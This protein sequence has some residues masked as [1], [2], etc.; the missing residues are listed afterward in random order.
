IGFVDS[1]EKGASMCIATP[2]GPDA[3]NR[4]EDVKAIQILLNMN[5]DRAG[6]S[7]ALLED[8]AWGTHT[9]EAVTTFQRVV[10]G[11]S[12]P[13]GHIAP[14]DGTLAALQAGMPDTFS[15]FKLQG[16]MPRAREEDVARF[17][18]QLVPTALAYKID[19]ALRQAH[20]FAQIGHE[21]GALRF[22][23]ELASGDA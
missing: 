4:F 23:E 12:N 20:F 7:T 8:G 6:I 2:V 10:M 3:S 18:P 19:T 22:T 13:G 1:P 14:S 21:S 17:F 5:R 15:T 9:E 16:T 11:M